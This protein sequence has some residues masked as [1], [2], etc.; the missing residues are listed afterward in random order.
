GLFFSI[1]PMA[2]QAGETEQKPNVILIITDDQGYGEVGAHGHPILK[3]PNLDRLHSECVRLTDFHVDPTC[4]PTRAALL[5]GR[6][7]TRTGVWHTINGRSMMRGEELTLPEIFKSNGYSTAMIGKWHLGTNYPCRPEDQGFDHTIWH[8]DGCIGGGPDYWGNDYFDDTYMTNG[9]WKPYKGYCTDVW[10]EEAAKWVEQK[11]DQPFF[12]YLATNAPHGPYIVEEKYSKPYA[13]TGMPETLAKFYGMITNIDENLGK[14]R[15]KLTDLGVA[16]N[17][18]LI[19]MTDNGTTAGWICMKSGY[20]YF[21]AGMRGW[22]SFAWEGGHRVP[23]F[24][25]WPKGGLKGGRD[26]TE[27]TAHIDVLPTLVDTLNLKKPDGPQ[28]DGTSIT[29]PLFG[30][31]DEKFPERTLFAHVQR[32]HTPPKWKASVAMRGPWRLIEGRQL[33]NLTS[34]PGQKTDIAVKHPDVVKRLR[35]DYEIWWKSMEDDIKQTVRISLG[36]K[37]NPTILYSHDWFM[38]TT[39]VTA[40]HQNHIRRGDLLNGPW[41]VKIEKDGRYEITLFRWAPYLNK[42]MAMKQARVEIAGVKKSLKLDANATE[43]KFEVEL[44]EGPSQLMTWLVRPD[45]SESG[46][47]YTRVKYLGE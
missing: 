16:D 21:N 8:F 34:D 11:K 28:L 6:Y 7:S 18:L 44:F 25:Y 42:E 33:Y 3:T 38:P 36:G 5:T 32:D 27:M 15:K 23:S 20:K 37:Q 26:V 22:K 43:A 9:K 40:W 17:T 45:G 19:Y 10:F 31:Q 1:I 47:Y 2:G 12:L 30:I 41:N 29:G 39:V 4:S 13:E 35:A 46:A 24:W 14:F